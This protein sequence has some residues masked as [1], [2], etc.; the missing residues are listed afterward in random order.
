M[1]TL[2]DTASNVYRFVS[3]SLLTSEDIATIE[4]KNERTTAAAQKAEFRF[5]KIVLCLMDV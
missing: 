4:E 2:T 3:S 1:Q 5:P